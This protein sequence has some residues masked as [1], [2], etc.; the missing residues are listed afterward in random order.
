MKERRE[1]LF[2]TEKLE[3]G[4][5]VF[6]DLLKT[7]GARIEKILSTGQV[8]ESGFWY[9][10]DEDEWVVLLEGRAAIEFEGGLVHDLEAGDHL[11]IPRHQKHRVAKCSNPALWLAVFF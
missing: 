5:E 2:S 3:Q 1:N 9:D 4:R 11:Y 10:Q 8:S 7:A 6:I